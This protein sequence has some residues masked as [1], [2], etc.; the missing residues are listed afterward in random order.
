M[1]GTTAAT[2]MVARS[3]IVGVEEDTAV[4]ITAEEEVTEEGEAGEI[5]T[6]K[7]PVVAEAAQLPRKRMTDEKTDAETGQRRDAMTDV[8]TEPRTDAWRG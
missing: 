4:D 3:A 5:L 6:E 1:E 8:S 2:G 7:I